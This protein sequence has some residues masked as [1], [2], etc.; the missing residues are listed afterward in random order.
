MQ[1]CVVT[2]DQQKSGN[3]PRLK[4]RTLQLPVSNQERERRPAEKDASLHIKRSN[5]ERI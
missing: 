3:Q 1:D 2:S 5:L 4:C